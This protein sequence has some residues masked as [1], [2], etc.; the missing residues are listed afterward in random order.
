MT[1][2]LINYDYSKENT[3]YMR[4]FESMWQK[5]EKGQGSYILGNRKQILRPRGWYIQREGV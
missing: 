3:L 2:F 4:Q 5:K 1:K